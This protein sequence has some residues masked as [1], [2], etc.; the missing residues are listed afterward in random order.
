MNIVRTVP[1]QCAN[2]T[3]NKSCNLEGLFA[4]K[5]CK[6]VSVSI[7][8]L[9]CPETLNPDIYGVMWTSMP[10]ITLEQ[11]QGRLQKPSY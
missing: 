2:Q 8:E 3:V 11:P 1:L 9:Q 4:C 5:S 10:E 6:L 7:I